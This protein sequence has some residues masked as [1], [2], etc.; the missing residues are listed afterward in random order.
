MIIRLRRAA[1]LALAINT[2]G[3]ASA[4]GQSDRPLNNQFALLV[5]NQSNCTI[6]FPDWPTSEGTLQTQ[7]RSA[8]GVRLPVAFKLPGRVTVDGATR[9]TARERRH[10]MVTVG[11]G[12]E[13]WVVPFDAQTAVARFQQENESQLASGARWRR[14]GTTRMLFGLLLTT[15]GVAG[16]ASGSNVGVGAGFVVV[17]MGFGS[18]MN[19]GSDFRRARFSPSERYRWDERQYFIG[20]LQDMSR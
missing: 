14:R 18:L 2:F 20:V 13:T 19:A 12:C 4:S 10:L 3:P 16:I 15:G 11:D 5:S 1:A 9:H 8:L 6:E 17:G 7:A